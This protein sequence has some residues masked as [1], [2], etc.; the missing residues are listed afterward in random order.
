[1]KSK[2]I[3]VDKPGIIRLLGNQP[4]AVDSSQRDHSAEA[5]GY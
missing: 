4:E 3:T 2:P 5:M 1:M